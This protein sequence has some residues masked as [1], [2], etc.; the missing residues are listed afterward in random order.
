MSTFSKGLS[1]HN[2][3]IVLLVMFLFI[4]FIH[5]LYFNLNLFV[6]Y[7]TVSWVTENTNI[8]T[9][10]IVDPGG[11]EVVIRIQIDRNILN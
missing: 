8:V 1:D 11:N 2:D 10:Q 4:V 5:H 3:V 7:T 9:G 6:T